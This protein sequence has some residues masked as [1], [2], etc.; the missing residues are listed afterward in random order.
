M[1][2]IKRNIGLPRGVFSVPSKDF[3]GLGILN[4]EFQNRCLL[5]KWLFRLINEDGVLKNLLRRK[6]LCNT[7]IT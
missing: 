1:R 6:Y 4:L 2:S 3:G 5:S 7:L